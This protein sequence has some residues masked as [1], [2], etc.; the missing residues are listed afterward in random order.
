LAAAAGSLVDRLVPVV[1]LL[2]AAAALV[3]GLTI[4]A[5]LLTVA[6]PLLV[7]V[8]WSWL[9]P[10]CSGRSPR[11]RPTSQDRPSARPVRCR[12]SRRSAARSLR[13]WPASCAT[14]SRAPACCSWPAA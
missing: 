13:P 2:L 12:A 4:G 11:S 9:W 3:G 6:A 8:S 1:A 7:G 5:T 14:A 10:G